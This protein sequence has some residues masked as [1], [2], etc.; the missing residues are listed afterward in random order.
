MARRVSFST[1]VIGLCVGVLLC[2]V[3]ANKPATTPHLLPKWPH[4][5]QMNRSTAIM[6][7]NN[8]GAYT[9]PTATAGW[10][11]LDFDWSNWKGTGKSDGWAKH[12]P[13][14]CQELMEEQVEMTTKKSPDAKMF[15]Y[16]NMIKALPW[17]TSVREKLTDPAYAK[18]FLPFSDTVIGN[19]TASHVPV[20]DNNYHPP[21]CSN[22]YHDQ[23]QTPGYP[24]GDGD[25]L[26]PGCDVGSVPVGEYLFDPRSANVS[27]NGQTLI[28]WFVDVYMGGPS[29]MGNPGIAGFYIDDDWGNMNP[30]GPSEMDRHCNE[31][32]GLS[33][34]VVKG[35]VT[36]YNWL[37]DHVYH[38]IV[39]KGKYAWD[40][41]LNNDPNCANCGDCPQ[42]WIQ[43]KS[44]AADLRT[45]CNASSPFQSRALLYGFSPGSCKGTNPKNLTMVK[46][47]VA[48]F[49]LVRGPYALIATGWVGCST[50]Y[51]YPAD[52][53]DAD[54]GEPT[55]MCKE[56]EAGSGIF[57][58]EWT[59]AKVQM[60]CNTWSPTI[61]WKGKETDFVM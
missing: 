51:P 47:D 37:A 45:Y 22:L 6:L 24:H 14:D 25:C 46:E 3:S 60:D 39:D 40:L 56:T 43:Q 16:R 30:N 31:D 1:T 21:L 17:F 53:M 5:Y 29:G 4:T 26:A 35:I 27:V 9:D 55:E 42:P 12:K 23:G 38:A 32:M 11:Y 49:L 15:V 28:E 44:C 52:I 48:N 13:M 59:N 10:S 2:E 50:T 54:Y 36:A 57:T 34:E 19:H 41:F 58:R 33:P 8:T 20:C 61:T 7:C 18:W